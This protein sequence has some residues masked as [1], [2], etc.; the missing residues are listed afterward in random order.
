MKHPK[1]SRGR[2]LFR[3]TALI[4]VVATAI[5][6]LWA[7]PRAG[8]YLVVDSS[9][10]PSDAIVILAGPRTE[11]WL[12]GVDL[13][14]E[15]LAPNLLLSS[16][17]IEP[18]EDALRQRGIRFP[19]EVDLI[20]DA[21]VQL[22][23]PAERILTFAETVDNTAAEASIAR[24][25][26]EQHGWHSIIVVT[27]K[28]HTRRSRFAFER[29]FRGTGVTIQLRATRYDQAQ[30]DTWW[31]HRADFRFVISEYPKL[32]AYRLGLGE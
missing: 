23:V 28:Y 16:G 9:L 3:R 29:A 2:R 17:R 10:R 18:A 14:K 27:S 21:M 12:E 8:R 24:T 26:V 6:L 32:L 19:R 7:W 13:Y 5:A 22:G 30:P 11:R 25:I 15:K 20:K 1:S 4:V 31:K